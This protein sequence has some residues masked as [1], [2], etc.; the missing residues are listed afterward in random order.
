MFGSR[1][2]GPF[3][4]L[5]GW[6]A[7]TYA[8]ATAAIIIAAVLWNV[9]LDRI[10]VDLVGEAHVLAD[11]VSEPLDA[12]DVAAV[13]AYVERVDPLTTAKILVVD[14]AGTPVAA[15]AQESVDLVEEGTALAAALAG[16]TVIATTGSL[17][18]RRTVIR[19]VVPV[20]AV[21]ES[22]NFDDLRA[23]FDR[24]IG[25]AMLGA[26]GAAMLAGLL[27]LYCAREIA[28]PVRR[29]A[30]AA[31]AVADRRR[32]DALEQPSRAPDELR[33]L[34]LAF[35]GMV[36][37]LAAHERARREFA[38]DVSHELHALASAMQTAADALERGSGGA[39]PAVGRRL[40]AGLVGHTRRLNRLSTDL[41]ELARWEGGRMHVEPEDL[42][43]ADLVHGVLD[44]WV[45]EA[46]RRGVSLRVEVPDQPLPLR[47]DPVRLA[48]ALGN[49]VENAL[50]YAGGRGSIEV[51]VRVGPGRRR[52]DV[53]VADSG[54]GIGPEDLPRVFERYYRVEGRT[55]SG[56]GGMGLGLA[57]ARGI[58]RAHDGDLV[59][60]SVPGDGARFILRLPA[61]PDRPPAPPAAVASTA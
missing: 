29:V 5:Q 17:A 11:R 22:Y 10:G 59:A 3:R 31:L 53:A 57:I 46:E 25:A 24:M 26:L 45:A 16:E 4:T 38:S 21:H 44:E 30:R 41:L 42:D 54:P 50:K 49:L 19:V 37:Q 43:V 32:L 13:R 7:A 52:Y 18:G 27:G 8:V 48:Q 56:P 47:G 61:P 12:G 36:A 51:A 40:V 14:R 39:D 60:E 33:H 15:S 23:V 9:V 1:W 58:A 55:G 6:L 34:V 35:N 20:G 28:R 2:L